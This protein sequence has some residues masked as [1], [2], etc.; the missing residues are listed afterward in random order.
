MFDVQGARLIACL[1]HGLERVLHGRI[2]RLAKWT[3][4]D[5]DP[6]QGALA[7]V[8][9]RIDVDHL[10]M[11]LQQLD[12]RQDAVT[13]QAVRVQVVRMEV[14][15]RDDADAVGEQRLQQAMQDHR[16]GDIRDVKLIETDETETARDAAAKLVQGVDGALEVLQFP[17]H[18][19]HELVEVQSRLAGERDGLE[20]AVHQ[21]AL[22]AAHTTMHVDAPRDGGPAQQL[23]QCIG[24]A[25]LVV[26]PFTLAA[27]Q[28]IDSPEL[29]GIAAKA[30][31]RQ[32]LGVQGPYPLHRRG[33]VRP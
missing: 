8:H 30:L 23:G 18:L 9:A 11:L 12:G 28:R 22:A 21:E 20:K 10:Q 33:R 17:V 31:Q 32:C 7:V 14:G 29:R 24:A 19:A 13:V 5:L 1:G 27:L 25:C 16:I 3:V 26:R 4:I 2:G 15:G 6:L